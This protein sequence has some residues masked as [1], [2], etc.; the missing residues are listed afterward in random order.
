[1]VSK[2]TLIDARPF[3]FS[4]VEVDPKNPDRVYAVSFQVMLSKD[5]GKNFKAIADSV[6]SD[7]HSMWIAPNDPTRIILGEDGG[8]ALTLDGGQNW[9]FSANLPIGQ[10]Y[11]VGLGTDNPYTVCAGLQDNNGWCGPSNSLD[12]SGIQNKYWIADTG[13]DGQW[14]IPEPDDPNWIWAYSTVS[15]KTVGLRRPTRRPRK[16]RGCR[17]RPSIDSTGSH[18]LRSRRGVPRAEA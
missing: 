13:G 16:N 2:D 1:M 15:R 9:F 5:G 11:R 17:R 6:H 7:F 18:R 8:Y 10:V 4:H 14:G 12:P 3:Y